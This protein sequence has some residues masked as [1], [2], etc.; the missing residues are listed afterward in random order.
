M[1]EVLEKNKRLLVFLFFSVYLVVG[2]SC[3]KDYGLSWD[4]NYQ[5]QG[6]GYTN[7][8]YIVHNNQ[9]ALLKSAD[10]YHG[11]AF[12]LTLVF[13]EKVFCIKDSRDVFFMRHLMTF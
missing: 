10:K 7:Y 8:N 12:E 4:E 6:N 11:P 1:H 3:Y 2:L 5:W 9:E 13:V